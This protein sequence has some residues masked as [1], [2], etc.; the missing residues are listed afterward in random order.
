VSRLHSISRLAFES[1]RFFLA[2]TTDDGSLETREL[3]EQTPKITLWVGVHSE[4]WALDAREW[5]VGA[6]R[7][8]VRNR[9]EEL[10]SIP[11]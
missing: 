1:L 7:L 6:Q 3:G 8:Q 10:S 4:K 2:A 11:R 5:P 9:S